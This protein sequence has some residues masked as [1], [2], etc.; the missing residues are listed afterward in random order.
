MIS[1]SLWSWRWFRTT[2]RT[3]TR[4]GG[5]VR[6]QQEYNNPYMSYMK[7]YLLSGLVFCD[8]SIA[9]IL[10][11]DKFVFILLTSR[12]SACWRSSMFATHQ[13]L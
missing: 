7:N 1:F 3:G 4:T 2:S 11:E 9:E 13:K 8:L 12:F 6:F 5:S 10:D